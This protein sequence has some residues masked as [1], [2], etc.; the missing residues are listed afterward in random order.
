M[1][2]F[3]ESKVIDFFAL[4][5][6]DFTAVHT[7]GSSRHPLRNGRRHIGQTDLS[8]VFSCGRLG[9]GKDHQL[10]EPRA[11]VITVSK[12]LESAMFTGSL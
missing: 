9:P 5:A 8:S 4:D 1:I 10:A 2:W 11:N 12:H 7:H 3:V 6:V